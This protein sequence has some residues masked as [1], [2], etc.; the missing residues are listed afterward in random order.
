MGSN[1]PADEV[2]AERRGPI[3]IWRLTRPDRMNA[4]S[5]ASVVQLKGIVARAAADPDLRAVI[6]TGEERA[7][8]AGADR[9]GAR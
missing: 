9:R 4:L 6:V 3:E 8:C 1:N 2:V 7:F 5:R